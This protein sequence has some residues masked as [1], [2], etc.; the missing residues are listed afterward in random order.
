VAEVELAGSDGRLVCAFEVTYHVIAEA[1]FISMFAD[2][3]ART[4]EAS[5]EDPYVTWSALPPLSLEGSTY[6]FR[7]GRVQAGR[8]LGHFVGFPAYPVSIMARDAILAVAEATSHKFGLAEA[9][10]RTVGGAAGTTRFAFAGDELELSV[11]HVEGSRHEQAWRAV[12]TTNGEDCAWFD[13]K[14]EV[15]EVPAPLSAA[16]RT[17]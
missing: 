14:L 16:P 17:G 2:R 9:R 11:T 5:G 10:V 6:K 1:E 12:F 4:D 3:R 8:C 7:F 15:S 13:M